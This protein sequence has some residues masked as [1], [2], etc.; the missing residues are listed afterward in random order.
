MTKSAVEV[1]DFSKVF[2]PGKKKAYHAVDGISFDVLR[3]QTVG[4]VGPNG[5]GKSTTLKTLLG[6]LSPTAG[7]I[8][9]FG[10][11]A[12]SIEARRR[13]GFMPEHPSF[14]DSL[15]GAEWVHYAYRLHH[16]K[17]VRKHAVLDIM[18]SVGLGHATKRLIRG[19]SKGMLQRLGLAQALI[20]KPDLL[21]LD[22]P[23][24]G[25]DPQGRNTFKSLLRERAAAGTTILFT[26]HI[27]DDVENLCNRILLLNKGKIAIDQTTASLLHDATAA[28][29]V[30]FRYHGEQL[31]D[32]VR[33]AV[34]QDDTPH[35]H[36]SDVPHTE[37]N[38]VIRT[39]QG[40][41]GEVIEIKR[42][43]ITLEELFVQI[44]A[45]NNKSGVAD[46]QNS[47]QRG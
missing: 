35:W 21:V 12:G 34:R 47:E 23:L 38:E 42:T 43:R 7:H 1:R 45:D 37:V 20:G 30:A 13:L 25:L 4:F 14:P 9:V 3:G 15:G 18:E 32:D 24:S 11:P 16:G 17:P 40:F 44:V 39:I 19:Y 41:G 10:Y 27:L 28:V 29:D 6:F 31:P 22:E 33:R 5:A 8:N 46:G 26:S 36:L 2:D